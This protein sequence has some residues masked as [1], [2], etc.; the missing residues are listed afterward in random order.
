MADAA[1]RLFDDLLNIEVNTLVKPGMTGRKMPATGHA[2]LD[3]FSDYDSW[4]CRRTE[5]LNERWAAFRDG[6]RGREFLATTRAKDQTDQW[7]VIDGDQL[8]AEIPI[9]PLFDSRRPFTA[10]DFDELRMRARLADEMQ[11]LLGRRSP[12]A[13]GEDVTLRRIVGN[14]DQLRAI[15]DRSAAPGATA[16]L[17]RET[18]DGI[19]GA[20][21]TEL[22]G[23]DVITLRKA[24]EM[25]TEVVVMQT[26]VQLDGDIVTRLN[27]AFTTE[28]SRP[29]RDLH[30]SSV[31]SAL[32]H[33]R[34]LVDTFVSITTKAIGFLTS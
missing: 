23:A 25:G 9:A 26:V 13:V 5:P 2:F 22:S 30:Q 20:T 11:R 21:L 1:K 31:G 28:E 29:I 7:W 14:C 17:T 15:L 3:V 6:E 10:K 12:L 18:A 33:W 8:V 34:F 27:A 16:T 4:L 19:Q 32:E 24:W